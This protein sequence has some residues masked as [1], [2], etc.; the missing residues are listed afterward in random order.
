MD[1]QEEQAQKRNAYRRLGVSSK[2]GRLNRKQLSRK[3]LWVNRSGKTPLLSVLSQGCK[4][5]GGVAICDTR[6]PCGERCTH[7]WASNRKHQSKA[8]VWLLNQTFQDSLNIDLVLEGPILVKWEY[9]VARGESWNWMK[10]MK[11]VDPGD[12]YSIILEYDLRIYILY[13]TIYIRHLGMS[14]ACYLSI[15]LCFFV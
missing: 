15:G 9:R 6:K 7:L 14:W 11:S 12:I 1:E 4:G 3:G 2:V 13:I 5:T 8:Y 10:S